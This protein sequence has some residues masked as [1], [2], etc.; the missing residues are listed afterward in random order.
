[1]SERNRQ[2]SVYRQ[3]LAVAHGL[4]HAACIQ[5]HGIHDFVSAT[6]LLSDPALQHVNQVMLVLDVAIDEG[7]EVEHGVV[8]VYDPIL[9][10][11]VVSHL[12]ERLLIHL[13]FR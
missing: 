13:D 2:N 9:G 6:C 5:L 12:R 4:I 1:M 8:E 3:T 7:A 11:G 10:V